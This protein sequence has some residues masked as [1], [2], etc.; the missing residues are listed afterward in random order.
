VCPGDEPESGVDVAVHRRPLM[1]HTQVVERVIEQVS[2]AR[3]V[4]AAELRPG[5]LDPF[6]EVDRMPSLQFP[7]DVLAGQVLLAEGSQR[8]EERIPRGRRRRIRHDHRLVDERRKHRPRVGCADRGVG[9]D[10]LDVVEGERPRKHRQTTKNGL[11]DRV[12]QIV[13]PLNG[14]EQRLVPGLGAPTGGEQCEAFIEA[15]SDVG[16]GDGADSRR[17]EFDGERDAVEPPA[18][19][20]DRWHRVGRQ[21]KSWLRRDRPIDEQP[22]GW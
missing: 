19:L 10:A 3:L 13:R 7:V 15:R 21:T 20:D 14:G 2:R 6:D 5:R 8:L 1:R 18:D 9:A 12:E 16:Q 11:L 17:R 22:D 4:G